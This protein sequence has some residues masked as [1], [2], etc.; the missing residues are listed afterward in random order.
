MTDAGAPLQMDPTTA[1]PPEVRPPESGPPQGRPHEAARPSRR[2]RLRKRL[3]PGPGMALYVLS[4]VIAELILGATPLLNFLFFGW[5]LCLLY[6]GGAIL[7]RELTLRWGRGWPTILALGV[8]YAI[9][10]EGIAVRTFFDPTAPA[11]GGL[12]DYGWAGGTNWVWAVNLSLYHAI[13]SIAL[14]IALVTMAFPSRAAEPWVSPKWLSRSTAGFA[15]FILFWL[16][17]YKR[18]V[19][20]GLIVGSLVAIAV[21]VAVARLLP[22][23]VTVSPGSGSAPSPRRVAVVVVL[24][25]IGVFLPVWFHGFGAPPAGAIAEMLAVAALGGWW[26]L[27]AS[28][29]PGWNDRHRFAFATGIFACMFAFSP[30]VELKGG[31]GQVLVAVVT[32]WLVRRTWVRLRNE[33]VAVAGAPASVPGAR[34]AAPA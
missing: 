8:A 22:A 16:A 28:G 17:A 4:P 12:V 11:L 34:L 6:G 33:A 21:I 14:P 18:P 25:T 15:G 1:R 30:F 27:R 2:A 20:G 32:A 24:T 29:R 31:H 7:I 9:A 3:T 23:R 19:D 13:V 10:E 5:F 26:L